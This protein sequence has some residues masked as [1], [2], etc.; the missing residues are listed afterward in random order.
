MSA[1]AQGDES[2]TLPEDFLDKS[3]RKISQ[4]VRELGLKLDDFFSNERYDYETPKSRLRVTTGLKWDSDDDLE[5]RTRLRLK[6]SLPNLERKFSVIVGEDS[7]DRIENNEDIKTAI[8]ELT[9]VDKNDYS[10]GLRFDVPSPADFKLKVNLDGGVKFRSE[11]ELYSKLRIRKSFSTDE[12]VLRLTNK[13]TW[14]TDDGFENQLTFEF[15][16]ILNEN[17]LIRV[18]TFG[19]WREEQTFIDYGHQYEWFRIIDENQAIQYSIGFFG[20]TESY[21]FFEA[22]RIQVNYKRRI[23]KKWLFVEIIPEITVFNRPDKIS[24]RIDPHRD[25]E[26]VVYGLEIRFEAQFGDW[27]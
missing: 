9:E 2:D 27:F 8:R 11:N 25:E 17:N 19:V 24:V 7:D 12:W 3:H 13:I 1:Q 4:E 10:A 5:L 18:I 6:M 21:P 14:E 15:E 26:E 16:K 22:S 23:L 20:H